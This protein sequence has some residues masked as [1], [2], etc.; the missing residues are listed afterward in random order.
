MSATSTILWI[1]YVGDRH[2]IWLTDSKKYEYSTEEMKRKHDDENDEEND[3]ER[4]FLKN[5]VG[6]FDHSESYHII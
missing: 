4:G 1:D 3:K 2:I 6:C 5:K